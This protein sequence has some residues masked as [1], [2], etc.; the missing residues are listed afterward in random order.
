MFDIAPH[1]I[2]QFDKYLKVP[3]AHIKRSK[4]SYFVQHNTSY[5]IPYKK[6]NVHFIDFSF[7]NIKASRFGSLIRLELCTQLRVFSPLYPIVNVHKSG[8]NI[9]KMFVNDLNRQVLNAFDVLMLS[10][11][12]IKIKH[13]E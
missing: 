11:F 3:A 10:Y 7:L 6:E 5:S 1:L 9:L 4:L 2:R 8:T 13:C 12:H